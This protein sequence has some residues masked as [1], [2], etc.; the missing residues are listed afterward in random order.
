MLMGYAIMPFSSSG[1]LSSPLTT[2]GTNGCSSC[3]MKPMLSGSVSSE[4]FQRNTCGRICITV[5]SPCG[6]SLMSVFGRLSLPL[7]YGPPY[8]LLG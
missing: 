2:S 5:D 7:V 8:T 3:A 4:L 1:Q 6:Q